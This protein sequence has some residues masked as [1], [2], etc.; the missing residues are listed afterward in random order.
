MSKETGTYERINREL[1]HKL[2]RELEET[3]PASDPLQLTRSVPGQSVMRHRVFEQE[4][5][6]RRDGTHHV[7][8]TGDSPK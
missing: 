4:E 8:K 5:A 1:D 3:F 6:I 2:D 7:L